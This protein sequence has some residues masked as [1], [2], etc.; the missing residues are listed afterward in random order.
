[1]KRSKILALL[2]SFAMM[3]TMSPGVT[4]YAAEGQSA[5][6]GET[7]GIMLASSAGWQPK[8]T[9]TVSSAGSFPLKLNNGDVLQINGPIEYTAPTGQSPIT[10]ASGANAKI[11]INGSV[12]LHGA[13]ASG[14]TGAT[15]AISVPEGAALTIYSA[16]DE[17]LS[18]STAAPKDT[19]TVTGGNAAAGENG[20]DSEHRITEYPLPI[21]PNVTVYVHGWYTGSGGDGGGGAAAAIGGNGGNGGTG[22]AKQKS[23]ATATAST[24]TH[25]NDGADD[26]DGGDGYAGGAASQGQ[27]AGTIYLSGR[28]NINAT[29]G[30]G[31]KGGDGGSGSGGYACTDG[32]DVMIGG[33]GGGGGG[34]GGLAAPAIGAG[35]SG[36]S[37][38]GSGGLLSSDV[39]GNVQGC[40][41]GGGG[42]GWPNGGGGGGGGSE[43]TKALD[44]KDNTSQGGKGGAGGAAG[45]IGS[46]GSAGTQTGT[47]D[48]GLNDAPPGEGGSGGHGLTSNASASGGAGGQEKDS[49]SY[50][51]GNGGNGGA[52]I[53]KAEWNTA[54][55][56]ILSTA[57]KLIFSSSTGYAYGD[58]QGYSALGCLSITPNII[59]DLMDCAITLDPSEY[60]YTGQQCR[61]S[62]KSIAY[63]AD[64]DRD[65]ARVG[66]SDQSFSTSDYSI[67]YGKNIHCP[68]GTVT[69]VGAQNANRTTVTAD[70]SVIG[71]NEQEFTIKKA[72]LTAEMHVSTTTPYRDQRFS[73]WL[74]AYTSDTAGSGSLKDLLRESS[75][76]A[77]GP[78]VVEWSFGSNGAGQ[79]VESD[80]LNATFV[81]K[82]VTTT[83]VRAH[84][85]D[86]NDFEDCWAGIEVSS[87][88]PQTFTATLS[89][90]TPHPRKEV[91]VTLPD[92]ITNPSYQWYADGT[93]I[94][95]ATGAA[96][97]PSSSDIGKTLSVKITPDAD[98]GYEPAMAAAKNA[99]ETH[100]YSANGFCTVCDE[101]EPATLSGDTYQIGN[102]G[103]MFWFASLVNGDKT[104]AEFAD[105]N[106][107][108]AG[109]LT[110]NIDLESRE[111][112]PMMGFNGSFDGQGHTITKL[113][114]TQKWDDIG[115]FG[116]SSGAI[117][118]FTLEG[119]ITLSGGGANT[120]GGVVGY[121][122]GG[123]VSQVISAVQIRNSDGT[124]KHVGGVV[125]GIENG[126]TVIKQCL[127]TGSITLSAS[128]DCIGGIL[129]YS[130]AGARISHCANLG[131]V[132]ATESGAY[133]GGIL[134]YL[135]NSNPSLKNCYN[136]GEVKNGG[137]DH[138]GAIIG[139]LRTH[140][141]AKITDN[142]YLD[143]SAVSAFGSGS[144]STSAK[145]PAKDEA[146]FKSGE[147]CYLV[148]GSSSADGVIWRQDVD[149]GDMPYDTYPVF[150]GGIVLQ[151]RAHH[152]C[153]AGEYT[154]AYSNSAK[155]EDHINHNYINGFCTCC[156]A[157]QS[158]EA[159]NGVYQ[160]TNGGQ[161][162]WFSEQ[163]N[164]GAIA[165]NSN[166]VLTADIDLEG[167]QN[168]QAAG[169][170][171][172][173]KDRNFPGIGT[174]NT[175]YGGVFTG[176]GY[177]IS[178]LYIERENE[179]PVKD[180]VG[181]FGYT[182]NAVI[183]ELIINGKILITGTA[184][185]Q[186]INIGGVI[187]HAET[188]QLSKAFSY[189]DIS[190]ENNE[191]THVGG[192]VG[193]SWDGGSISQCMY[194]GSIDLHDT[195]DSIGGIVGYTN[196]T[197]ISYCANHGSVKTDY[198]AGYVGGI[199]G[200]INNTGG[201]VRNCYNYGEVQNGGGDHCGA[202]I[203]WLKSHSAAKITDNYYLDTSATSAFGS[204]SNGTTAAAPAKTAAEFKSGE[205]CYLVNSKTSTGDKA[206]WKQ[207]IDN[208]NT[209][210]DT[211]PLFEAAAVYFR[212]DGTYS[213]DPE[214]ISI[215]ISWGAMEFDYHAG[216][217]DPD[218][219][220]YSGGWSPTAADGNDLSVQNNSNVALEAS[221]TFTAD[222]AFTPYS[223]TG[224]FNGVADGANRMERGATLSTELSVKS[225]KP[226]SLETAGGKQ[227]IGT[228]TV[229]LTT[230]GG[231]GD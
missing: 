15:A 145:A 168:G 187:G 217:W 26:N 139:W 97:T 114:I 205:V 209:P 113:K 155:A 2:L 23:P 18:T 105:K 83:T 82:S 107:A 41:G 119:N 225:L 179:T 154:Y 158:A 215:T 3:L 161:L 196:T 64:S 57:A 79:C 25:T 38:G 141:A 39:K 60:T 126:E 221:F 135:N 27:G 49:E 95:G 180:G 175:Q 14:T 70:K 182:K 54:G 94:S 191:T 192:L 194:F 31:A 195:G 160:I 164:S 101:Y 33:C 69:V 71:T 22:G 122:N 42:G 138:C 116:S 149:N 84:L 7:A 123:A 231:G 124:Y 120:V 65:G 28:L 29:G 34:G 190:N 19:L 52:A 45:E 99:V 118:G 74:D 6:D 159:I 200:Y 92:G 4:S 131:T 163:L 12:T 104:H 204:G 61:P 144:N 88:L 226:A 78:Q 156:D 166:A 20:E 176:G 183:T 185:R 55:S 102:G 189:V 216:R 229:R 16:H 66:D 62:V 48:H 201:S 81:F 13:D 210:Y 142:Y 44:E 96:Y 136:Y 46:A 230:V 137:G 197:S 143:T 129:G 220:K 211:Y 80:G 5:S 188:T 21:N 87:Q 9:K 157:R 173:T 178:D 47:K 93:A 77:E 223:L 152:D 76:T 219:H 177:T 207:D 67:V 89:T 91:S 134:G 130:R 171:G 86:M 72:K 90:D 127:F 174:I 228:I 227:K 132:T 51:G 169:Y 37:G 167:S 121:A 11:I 108:A 202:I 75:Q 103:Q 150:D 172:V 199:L 218:T 63:S 117:G 222:A 1:M 125:G 35:G 112:S 115:F 59:Y 56:L 206:I 40:G 111:W 133:V 146:A 73:A 184:S 147:V 8:P 170:D 153:T 109:V 165:T 68:T 50:D 128:I 106:T 58:G 151:N 148:N 212:S 85:T 24:F 32:N 10:L 214:R 110:S 198:N 213:N 36:G 100:K 98:A 17:E 208:G 186:V 30:A 181:L 162:F 224:A 43:C 53:S 193:G 203:G 140:S